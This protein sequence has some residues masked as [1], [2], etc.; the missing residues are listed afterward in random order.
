MKIHGGIWSLKYGSNLVL[1][2]SIFLGSVGT[3]LTPI[4]AT[5]DIALIF[6]RFFIGFVHVIV[7][8]SYLYHSSFT[9]RS[10]LMQAK[11]L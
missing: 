10:F 2:L 4:S 6:C 5:N 11:C 8:F 9:F 3:L 7:A 1:A